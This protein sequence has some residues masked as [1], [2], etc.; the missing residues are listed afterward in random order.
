[1]IIGL[2]ALSTISLQILTATEP[3]SPV[4][5][6]GL[7]RAL[8]LIGIFG[9]VCILIGLWMLFRLPTH[10]QAIYELSEAVNEVANHNYKVVLNL[11]GSVE[12]QLLS[13]NFNRMTH[14]LQDYHGS[15]MSQLKT[16]KQYMET[17]INSI[18]E[19]IVCLGVDGTL[20]IN[21]AGALHTQ[22][23]TRR[24]CGEDGPGHCNA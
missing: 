15:S 10:Q 9:A 20:L 19:P 7:N 5:D 1:M 6:Y 23:K 24:G 14:R 22:H 2:V 17:I 21:N 18:D 13:Q 3:N 16:S 4:A 12:L 8:L 11:K